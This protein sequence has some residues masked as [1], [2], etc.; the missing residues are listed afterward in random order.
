ML[1]PCLGCKHPPH[2]FT[3]ADR[4]RY[5]FEDPKLTRTFLNFFQELKPKY[6]IIG[7]KHI[8]LTHLEQIVGLRYRLVRHNQFSI[9]KLCGTTDPLM[10]DFN[11][12]RL[13]RFD[14]IRLKQDINQL[15]KENFKTMNDVITLLNFNK[16][17]SALSLL[18][19]VEDTSI[20]TPNLHLLKA[21]ALIKLGE[22]AKAETEL[23]K[24][25]A[26]NPSNQEALNTLKTLATNSL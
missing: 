17:N 10:S 3:W 12:D 20:R 23:R 1:Y 22:T 19:T 5:H 14:R 15:T 7:L 18:Q 16:F 21:L 9:Y 13:F 6:L 4:M 2:P 11:P 26:I 25:I 24:E 8:N